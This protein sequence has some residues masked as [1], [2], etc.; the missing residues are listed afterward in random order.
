[1]GNVGVWVAGG[2]RVVPSRGLDRSGAPEVSY[3]RP[4]PVY[5]PSRTVVAPRR[6]NVNINVNNNKVNIGNQINVGNRS[7]NI[8]NTGT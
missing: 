4:V 1:M 7:R 2:R 8:D 6:T 3:V 5:R